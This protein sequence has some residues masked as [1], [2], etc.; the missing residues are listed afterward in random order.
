MTRRFSTL[1]RMTLFLKEQ[2]RCAECG[3]PLRP[4]WH[5]DHQQPF[6]K[7]GQTDVLNDQAL[8]PSCNFRKGNRVMSNLIPWPS[9]VH[10]RHWQRRALER[11]IHKQFNRLA[12]RDSLVVATPGSGKTL[13]ALSIAHT[14]LGEGFV[15][16]LVIVTPTNHL[17]FQW[18]DAADTVGIHLDPHWSNADGAEADDFHGIKSPIAKFP[19]RPLYIACKLRSQR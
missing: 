12:Q 10:L 13:L 3:V 18:A 8:C 2:G 4:G 15:E 11:I 16:R 14:M 1:Q 7:G 9:H 17:R 5:A 19:S 6:S